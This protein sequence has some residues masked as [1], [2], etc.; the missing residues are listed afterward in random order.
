MSDARLNLVV[1]FLPIDKLSG[2]L[3][4]IVGLGRSGDQALRGLKREA[5]DLGM[6]LK[7]AQAASAAGMG[8]VT[9]LI[10]EER[11]LERQIAQTNQQIER[12]KRLNAIDGRVGRVQARGAELQ[13][14]GSQNMLAGAGMLTP[15]VLAG[16]EAMRFSSGMVDIQQKAELTNRETAQMARNI[17]NLYKLKNWSQ[18]SIKN[19]LITWPRKKMLYFPILKRS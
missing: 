11:R 10:A 14:A 9:A 6:Q 2:A 1:Q 13:S 7:A 19:L 16:N 5:R 15:F 8:N 18:R 3:K 4:N 17:L 12:Q